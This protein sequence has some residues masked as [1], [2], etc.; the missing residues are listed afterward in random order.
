MQK[1]YDACTQLHLQYRLFTELEGFSLLEP[2][3]ES[4]GWKIAI[5]PLI[6]WIIALNLCGLNNN[7]FYITSNISWYQVCESLCWLE[8]H[9]MGRGWMETNSDHLVDDLLLQDYRRE[10]KIIH[11]RRVS[12][13]CKNVIFPMIA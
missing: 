13:Q 6:R 12:K 9:G 2:E 8:R 7:W 11:F 3:G 10:N 4:Q 5:I 1:P